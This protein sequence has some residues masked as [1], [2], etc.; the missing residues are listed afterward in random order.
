MA[1]GRPFLA[2]GEPK[3]ENDP[4]IAAHREPQP[5]L[6]PAG[7]LTESRS[8]LSAPA[9]WLTESPTRPS[10]P[11]RWL[12]EICAKPT[13]A[14]MTAVRAS[15]VAPSLDLVAQPLGLAAA[16]SHPVERA[17]HLVGKSPVSGNLLPRAAVFHLQ[18]AALRQVLGRVV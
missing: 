1:A 14:F 11:A 16:R 7:W 4:A 9:G 13:V 17:C 8:R 10:S 2:H 5:A 6:D 12:T 15:P 3:I 18:L